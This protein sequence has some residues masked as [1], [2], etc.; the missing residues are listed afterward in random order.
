MPVYP[1]A[2]SS[3]ATCSDTPGSC[4]TGDHRWS[5]TQVRLRA[6]RSV[7]EELASVFAG[8]DLTL[9]DFTV[10]A[11]LRRSGAHYTLG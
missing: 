10:I 11:T 9:V 8:Y 3:T 4:P 2:S 7:N 5:A 1:G 6:P